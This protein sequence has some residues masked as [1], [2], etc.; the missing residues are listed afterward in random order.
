MDF[1][2]Q[3]K[4]GRPCWQLGELI[5]KDTQ[6][7]YCANDKYFEQRRHLV[8]VR[9]SSFFFFKRVYDLVPNSFLPSPAFSLEGLNLLL[10]DVCLLI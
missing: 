10:R 8:D 6:T 1:C 4:G 2:L 9:K 5:E 3:K 7:E